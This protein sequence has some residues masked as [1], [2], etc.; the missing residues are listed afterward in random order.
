VLPE[1]I[2]DA[3]YSTFS[4]SAESR[5]NRYVQ[6]YKTSRW[7]M[8]SDYVLKHPGRPHDVFAFTLVPGGRHLAG[9]TEDITTRALRGDECLNASWFRTLNDV[10]ACLRS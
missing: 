8:F 1:M 7:L 2:V 6:H 5:F 9:I 10:R 3:L 4:Q